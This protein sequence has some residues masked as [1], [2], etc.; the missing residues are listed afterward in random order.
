MLIQR[1]YRYRFY[2][3]PE[4][5]Q[6]LLRTF[7]SV[8]WVYN[9]GLQRRSEAFYLRQERIYYKQLAAE[10]AQVKRQPETAWLNEVSSVCLQQALRHLDNAFTRFFKKEGGF[11]QFKSRKSDQS[12]SYMANAFTFRAGQ[13]TL[14]KQSTPLDIRWSRPLPEGACPTSITV[15]RTRGGKFFLSLLVE[16]ERAPLP[17]SP[18]AVGIDLN[19]KELVC[20]DGKRFQTPAQ[21]QKLEQ[22]KRRYQRACRRKVAAARVRAGLDPKAPI[23]KGT[24]LPTSNN[25]RKARLKVART[26]EHAANVRRDWQHK[27]TTALIREHQVIAVE[28]LNTRGMTAG[29]R[30][31]EQT[32]GRNVR[33]KAGLNR[34]VLDVG[35]GEIRRQL[36]YKAQWNGRIVVAID[37]WYPSSKRCSHCGHVLPKL[38]LSKRSWICPQCE[39]RHD[40]DENAARNILA[41]G[42]AVLAGADSLRVHG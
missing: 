17:A 6:N 28:D 4:Q 30:G 7:G 40:R 14:A 34:A 27:T 21:L 29:A 22:R 32:P 39:T 25:L 15:T 8:R 41:A 37:R 13:I 35:F 12:C 20:S 42:R 2:P 24:R 11:P 1:A 3:T 9:W 16:E 19:T 18:S 5:E 23:P 10:L 36:E 31:D 33:Q 26:M 38:P